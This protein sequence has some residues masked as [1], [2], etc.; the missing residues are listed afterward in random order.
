MVPTTGQTPYLQTQDYIQVAH[1]MLATFGQVLVVD[2]LSP[3]SRALVKV[4]LTNPSLWRRRHP[5]MRQAHLGQPSNAQPHVHDRS[6]LNSIR[7]I[8]ARNVV[9]VT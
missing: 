7:K 1:V 4:R 9:L 6:C 2:L 8:D 3:F 5:A